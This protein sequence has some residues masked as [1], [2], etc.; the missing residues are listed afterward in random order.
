MN[1]SIVKNLSLLLQDVVV[2]DMHLSSWFPLVE[3]VKFV[4]KVYW[5]FGVIDTL[6]Q[7]AVFADAS[8]DSRWLS[9]MYGTHAF[10]PLT[11]VLVQ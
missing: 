4:Y 3:G 7:N 1:Y 6:V 11:M 2:P 8:G 5:C 9:E 10:T